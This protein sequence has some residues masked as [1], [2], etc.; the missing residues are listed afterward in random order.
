MRKRA[1]LLFSAIALSLV[2]QQGQTQPLDEGSVTDAATDDTTKL[3]Q[4]LPE[5]AG[6][7]LPALEVAEI[8]W[9]A[10]SSVA[11]ET[12]YSKWYETQ[13]AVACAPFRG[14][15]AATRAEDEWTHRCTRKGRGFT[16]E[17]S[18]YV[19]RLEELPYSRLKQFR[20]YTS[21]LSA[22][23]IEI[24]RRFLQEKFVQAYG[25]GKLP[26]NSTEFGSAFWKMHIVWRA[27]NHQIQLYRDERGTNDPRLALLVRHTNLLRAME[28]DKRL[29]SLHYGRNSPTMQTLNE[30][31]ARELSATFPDFLSLLP[32]NLS[33]ESVRKLPA[34][35]FR[36][37]EEARTASSK[38]RPIL[39]LAADRLAG[40][41]PYSLTKTANSPP[42]AKKTLDAL[43]SHGLEFADSPL[44]GAR[45]YQH[46]L[47]KKVWTEYPLTRWGEHAHVEL[48]Y[49]GWD[50]SVTCANGSDKFRAV[51]E[52][53]EKFLAER[54]ESAVR[55]AVLFATAQAYETWWSLSRSEGD[56]AV[57]D[58]YQ[59]GAESAR[60]K[61]IAY[62]E[63]IMAHSPETVEAAYS[64]RT[65]PRLKLSIYT[66]E[67]RFFCI[68][69]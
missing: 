39:L 51:I 61:A 14:N 47:L 10:F 9:N 11:W 4:S 24:V 63:Q 40:W 1:V 57:A 18:F 67:R 28:E 2:C 46:N 56:Y 52:Q 33:P 21:E 53:G 8:V 26:E 49:K 3:S 31:L 19:F 37:L 29:S 17:W 62:Y 13:Q 16:L 41:L 38:Q 65:L 58:N 25:Q 42:E 30:T 48:L 55:F 54:P 45:V 59:E 6:P 66:N 34:T 7:P 23:D 50:T 43:E 35:L 15:G 60:R 27:D 32:G 36:L 5:P 68:Y 44:E 22:A 69:D 20:A 64:R 12:H